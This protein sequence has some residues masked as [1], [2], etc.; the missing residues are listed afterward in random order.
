MDRAKQEF[1]AFEREGWNAVASEYAEFTA[2][3]TS[4]VAEALLDAANVSGDSRVVDVASG[5]GWTAAAAA[6]RGAATIGV[7][8]SEAMVD[9]ASA[10]FSDVD[11][12]VG[13]AEELPLDDQSVDAVVS[14][15]GMPHFADHAAFV[16]ESARVLDGGGRIAFASWYPPQTN[17]FFAV[18]LGSIAKHG[19]LNVPLPDGVD[20]FTWADDAACEQL[21]TAGGFGPCERVDVPLAVR[22]S[23]GVATVIGFLENASVRSRALFG[24]QTPEAQAAITTSIS[25]MLAPMETNGQWTI[26]LNAFVVSA[27]KL[28]HGE[29]VE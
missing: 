1:Q 26:P 10:R 22:T 9:Q 28:R 20:M 13:S 8:I 25:E 6:Q 21:L 18:A 3:V 4:D 29:I 24:A 5:P 17:P 23:N 7:D 27:S 15:F 11:F 2:G 16:A 12:R 19:D 14:A